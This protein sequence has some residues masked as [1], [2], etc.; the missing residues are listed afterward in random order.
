MGGQ[1]IVPAH[2]DSAGPCRA[3]EGR[4]FPKGA[5]E[6]S[7]ALRNPGV[8]SQAAHGEDIPREN[9]SPLPENSVFRAST[10]FSRI[11]SFCRRGW[12]R[13]RFRGLQCVR[14]CAG[15]PEGLSS[16]SLPGGHRHP[17]FTEET[18]SGRGWASFQVARP[19]WQSQGLN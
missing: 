8:G 16:L 11:F 9:L 18:G 13:Q 6:G 3:P 1:H 10:N 4:G 17:H 7:L 15:H 2:C 14:P 19:Q 5:G 12:S